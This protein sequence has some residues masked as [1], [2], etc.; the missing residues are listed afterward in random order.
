ML[1]LYMPD[2]IGTG[3]TKLIIDTA[4]TKK[5]P[6]MFDES[7]RQRGHLPVWPKFTIRDWPA[8]GQSPSSEF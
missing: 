1:F 5:L 3:E 4:K 7:G 6:N 2:A 8:F